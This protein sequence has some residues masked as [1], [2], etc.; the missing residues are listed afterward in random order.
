MPV[1]VAFQ[2]GP[3]APEITLE[4]T[5]ESVKDA[6]AELE[7]LAS[8]YGTVPEARAWIA[9][10]DKPDDLVPEEPE[11]EAPTEEPGD[12]PAVDPAAAVAQYAGEEPPDPSGAEEE[13]D[14]LTVA[15]LDEV[16]A[17]NDVEDYPKSGN[18]AEKLAALKAAGLSAA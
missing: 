8:R 7:S 5:F 12:V 16:A 17:E 18:K 2:N 13:L 9:E 4:E 14:T 15:E 3:D 10:D 11:E 1:Q 6:K